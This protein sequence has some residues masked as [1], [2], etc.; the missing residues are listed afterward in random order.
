MSQWIGIFLYVDFLFFLA[1]PTISWKWIFSLVFSVFTKKK[2]ASICIIEVR[3]NWIWEDTFLSFPFV[4]LNFHSIFDAKIWSIV[5]SHRHR[6][7]HSVMV[8]LQK[9]YIKSFMRT[10]GT[11]WEYL[12]KSYVSVKRVEENR[13]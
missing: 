12:G 13:G 9:I 3:K 11:Y 10:N 5:N 8:Y 6:Q 7:L 4:A 1:I 2:N